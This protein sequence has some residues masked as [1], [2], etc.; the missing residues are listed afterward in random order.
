LVTQP[1][2]PSSK[3]VNSNTFDPKLFHYR[4]DMTSSRLLILACDALDTPTI[5]PAETDWLFSSVSS[6]RPP[7]TVAI[8]HGSAFRDEKVARRLNGDFPEIGDNVSE[9]A[10]FKL[11]KHYCSQGIGVPNTFVL[12]TAGYSAILLGITHHMVDVWKWRR[13]ATIFTWIGANA[14][15]LYILNQ[16]VAERIAGGDLAASFDRAVTKG[17]G[18]FVLHILALALAIILARFMYQRKIFV[19]V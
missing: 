7:T 17:A 9:L 13:W 2:K 5:E 14:I 8:I 10:G 4:T 3:S 16:S 1:Q 6:S 12:V 11:L 18:G 19:R 15:T